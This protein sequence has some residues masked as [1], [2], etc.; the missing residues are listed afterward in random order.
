MEQTQ[1]VLTVQRTAEPSGEDRPWLDI[2]DVDME[3]LAE[4]IVA[5]LKKEVWQEQ[6]RHGRL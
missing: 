5:L 3:A 2:K 6:D 4:E 1:T